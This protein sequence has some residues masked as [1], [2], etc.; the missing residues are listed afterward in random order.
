MSTD[1]VHFLIFCIVAELLLH[2][3][4]W[5]YFAFSALTLL[6]GQQEGHPACKNLSGGVL[7]W[8]SVW[9]EVHTCIWP[10]WCYCH[11]L[12]HVS[13]KSRLVFPF[14]YQLTRVV[15]RK[16]CEMC[17][18]VCVCVCFGYIYPRESEGLCFYRRWFVCLFVCL[19]VCLFVTTITK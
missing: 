1:I 12:S 17:V 8:L 4:F 3:S 18:C 9:S 16:G 7:V 10:S 5:I 13:V 6:V 14:W 11:S 19:S 2:V 15:P